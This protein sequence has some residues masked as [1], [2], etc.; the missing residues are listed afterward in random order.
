MGRGL[1]ALLLAIL[2]VLGVVVYQ[3]GNRLDALEAQQAVNRDS[4]EWIDERVNDVGARQ[5]ATE[6]DITLLKEGA[7][8]TLGGR[9]PGQ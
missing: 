5:D 9:T 7:R 8:R 1:I 2:L 3:Q 6:H 4:I